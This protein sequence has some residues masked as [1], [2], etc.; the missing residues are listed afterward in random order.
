MILRR[1]RYSSYTSSYRRRR[2]LSFGTVLRVVLVLA[3][4]AV[5]VFAGYM[6]RKALLSDQV[7]AGL[8]SQNQALQQQVDELSAVVPDVQFAQSMQEQTLS[9]QSLY[10]EMQVE[11]TPSFAAPAA[12][13][14]YLTFD[15]GPSKNTATVL[16]AL[17]AAN[18]KA[19]FFVIGKNIAGNEALL[20]R[21]VDEGHTIGIHT[22]SHDY[23]AIYTSVEAY[24][25]DFH[26]TYQAIYNACGV[27]PTIFRFPGGSVN[28]YSRGVYQ[29]I[30]AELLRRG[31]VYYDWSVSS[32]DAT[33]TRYTAAHI[34]RAVTE[35]V[36]K[37]EIPIVLLHDG[38]EKKTTAQALPGILS[39]LTQ[40][41]YT[42][43]PLTN[44][45]KPVTFNYAE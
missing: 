13:T 4:L 25:E 31:F 11:P 1:R 19:T 23:N 20:K 21:M 35:G 36:P 45:V 5:I 33:G 42:C 38:V 3:V 17:K 37:V 12:N 24:L 32:E 10:P 2:R 16:D 34:T 9:Y 41:G 43:A 18:Q 6:V 27:Y 29:Q 26:Q 22:Y 14:V 40:A 7:I 39:S 28:S 15:D 44:T 30:I 8:E